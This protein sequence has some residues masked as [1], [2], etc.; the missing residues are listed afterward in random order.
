MKCLKQNNENFPERTEG[1]ETAF[2]NICVLHSFIGY[3]SV[4]IVLIKIYCFGVGS[5]GVRCRRG[6]WTP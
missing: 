3:V 4:Y 6:R 2:S 1:T 5:L